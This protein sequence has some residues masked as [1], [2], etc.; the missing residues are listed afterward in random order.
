MNT[1]KTREQLELEAKLATREPDINGNIPITDKE[2]DILM[3]Q[4]KQFEKRVESSGFHM[5]HNDDG[6]MIIEPS[7]QSNLIPW[8]IAAVGTSCFVALVCLLTGWLLN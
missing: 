4:W 5:T 7:K 2:F 1:R 8:A 6:S 3:N